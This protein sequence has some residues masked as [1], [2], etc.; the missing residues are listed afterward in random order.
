[1]DKRDM[2]TDIQQT[3]Q[4]LGL[5]IMLGLGVYC[6]YTKGK[7]DG[8]SEAYSDVRTSEQDARMGRRLMTIEQKL[9]IQPE[10]PPY[11]YGMP[12]GPIPV[13]IVVEDS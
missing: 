6:G 5:L 12:Q 13:K 11:G 7:N 2:Q 9:D 3:K 10:T 8:R 4:L 1:M